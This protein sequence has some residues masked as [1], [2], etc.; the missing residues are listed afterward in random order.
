MTISRVVLLGAVVASIAG[1]HDWYRTKIPA[2][3]DA[4]QGNPR[5]V[6]V[7]LAGG[8]SVVMKDPVVRADSLFGSVY[9][10]PGDAVQ[11]GVPIAGIKS[12]EVVKFTVFGTIA[13]I[14]GATVVTLGFLALG[15][16]AGG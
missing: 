16:A 8:T 12:L 11:L 1:C 13:L 14:L 6:R 15:A 4:L 10:G 2:P 5:R 9:M 3:A 7:T